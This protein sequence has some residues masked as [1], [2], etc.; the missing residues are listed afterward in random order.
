M[1]AEA[2]AKFPN[3]FGVSDDH[4]PSL[5]VRLAGANG[6][7]SRTRKGCV[8]ARDEARPFWHL[9]VSRLRR[10]GRH[11][12]GKRHAPDDPMGQIAI[13]PREAW[14]RKPSYPRW[15]RSHLAMRSHGLS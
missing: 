10:R 2:N 9:A 12:P 1:E 5:R 4:P 8:G 15:K 14:I 11:R 3:W 7:A 6:A 13:R